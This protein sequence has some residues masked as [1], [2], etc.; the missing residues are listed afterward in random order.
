V[1]SRR[2]GGLAHG[3]PGLPGSSRLRRAG[4]SAT[5]RRREERA[6]RGRLPLWTPQVFGGALGQGTRPGWGPYRACG[7]AFRNVQAGVNTENARK[8]HAFAE[9]RSPV[10]GP[11]PPRTIDG[12]HPQTG[13]AH[14]RSPVRR[15]RG[16]RKLAAD[17][18]DSCRAPL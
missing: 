18:R 4:S 11:L 6:T 5:P 3:R 15:W 9:E 12:G 13:D 2:T 7:R 14:H 16:R 10:S 17:P 1:R 8:P